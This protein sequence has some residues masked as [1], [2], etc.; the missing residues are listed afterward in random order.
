VAERHCTEEEKQK[1]L[2]NL[3][4]KKLIDL[5]MITKERMR[6]KLKIGNKIWITNYE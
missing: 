1:F 5:L 6:G 4:T 3:K 2:P